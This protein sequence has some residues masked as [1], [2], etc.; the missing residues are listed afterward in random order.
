MLSS[1]NVAAKIR[2]QAWTTGTSCLA[3]FV[4][5]QLAKAGIDEHGLNDDDADDEIG[6]VERNDGNDRRERV[7]QRVADDDAR[8]SQTLEDRHLD[9]GA[10][11]HREHGGARHAHH[12][13]DDDQHQGQHRQKRIVQ[14]IAKARVRRH[15]G[16]RRKPAEIDRDV[17]DEEIGEKILGHRDRHEREEIDQ[18]VEYAALPNRRQESEADRQ[19][20]RRRSRRRRRETSCWRSAERFRSARRGRWPA[21]GRNRRAARRT[22]IGRSER[23]QAD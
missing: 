18:P 4:D 22:A 13:G 15:I 9:I 16:Q 12:V 3:D 14:A 17:F 19:A 23:R 5:H 7:R 2:P 6:E 21:S 10:R 1:M 8:L 11:H 20:A